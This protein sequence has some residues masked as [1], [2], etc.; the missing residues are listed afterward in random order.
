MKILITTG[1]FPPDIGGP[2]TYVE[3]IGE[4]FV[5]LGHKI[6]VITY[7]D[8]IVD[9]KIGKFSVYRVVRGHNVLW[10]YFKYFI[11]VLIKARW[12]DIIYTQDPVSAGLPTA[13]ANLFWRKPLA[14]KVVG[15]FAWEQAQNQ[16]GLHDDLDSF[17]HQKYGFKIELWRKIE[18]WVAKR[19]NIIITPSHYLKKIV[20]CWGQPE[21]KIRVIYN[22]F[23]EPSRVDE[24]V[25]V[26]EGKI[27][28][29]AGRLVPWKGID[30]LI[31]LMPDLT[32]KQPNIK[33]LIAGDGPDEE[34]LKKLVKEKKLEE[35]II[36]LGRQPREK[37]LGYLKKSDIF[38]LNSSYEGLSHMVLEAMWC[39]TPVAI[40]RVGGNPEVVEDKKNGLLFCYNSQDEI[41]EAV[42]KIL[43][44]QELA[45][46]FSQQAN[47]KLDDFSLVSMLKKTEKELKGLL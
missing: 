18:H 9:S 40:S 21:D 20:G 32:K 13:V 46:E 39:K 25:F 3:K 44:N 41:K 8:E 15:D 5:D 38:V 31:N 12:A 17:Q 4:E 26:P 19:A 30:A 33:M 43:G 45:D 37:L 29:T 6:K 14:L 28:I 11:K 22:A 1:I 2:A 23:D 36:F 27:I 35:R 7:S 24:N 42:L 10:R 34:R 47:K 16:F